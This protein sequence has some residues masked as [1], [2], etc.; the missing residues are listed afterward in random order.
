MS[1]FS[2]KLNTPPKNVKLEFWIRNWLLEQCA[3]NANDETWNNFGV[4]DT[5]QSFFV[6]MCSFSV[7]KYCGHKNKA[8]FK[9]WHLKNSFSN[10][11]WREFVFRV[12]VAVTVIIKDQKYWFDQQ[13]AFFRDY[14]WQLN[15]QTDTYVLKE[16]W[17]YIFVHM[18]SRYSNSN[19]LVSYKLH[20][21]KIPSLKSLN[22]KV[23]HFSRFLSIMLMQ[24][25]KIF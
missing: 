14:Y 19:F 15:K 21:K 18:C 7:C 10:E 9:T 6:M 13:W 23:E 22:N 4:N 8:I 1:V 25:N 11:W 24:Q 12:F 16:I 17:R 2:P 5:F 3:L 20:D